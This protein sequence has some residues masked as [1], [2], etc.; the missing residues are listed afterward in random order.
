MYISFLNNFPKLH[1]DVF[2]K[3]DIIRGL[4]N[5]VNTANASITITLSNSEEFVKAYIEFFHISLLE[6]HDLRNCE[7]E[8]EAYMELL[9]GF[10]CMVFD[11][12]G[13]FTLS[14]DI[15]NGRSKYSRM[16][17]PEAVNMLREELRNRVERDG[18][19]TGKTLDQYAAE[20]LDLLTM[21][22]AQTNEFA[23]RVYERNR[24]ER[25]F[26]RIPDFPIKV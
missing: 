11:H 20:C 12:Y 26:G 10:Q 1:L 15:S 5:I 14:S 2:P 4:S 25:G 6:I 16:R 18:A 19:C 8:D 17:I 23:K 21:T 13:L 24:A 3:V 7:S 9:K 22:E